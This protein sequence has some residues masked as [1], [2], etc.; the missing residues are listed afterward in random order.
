MN[1]KSVVKVQTIK[2][3]RRSFYLETNKKNV[4]TVHRFNC[5]YR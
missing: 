1:I 2:T 3:Y 5:E 4:A